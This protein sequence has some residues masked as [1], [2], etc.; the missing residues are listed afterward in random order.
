MFTS[1]Y[2]WSWS[3]MLVCS[4]IYLIMVYHARVRVRVMV[5]VR[6]RDSLI[7]RSAILDHTCSWS[8][9]I[10]VD[11]ARS[12]STMVVSIPCI[13]TCIPDWSAILTQPW[14]IDQQTTVEL[15]WSIGVRLLEWL[16]TLQV[17]V[18]GVGDQSPGNVQSLKCTCIP[19]D[20]NFLGLTRIH[21]E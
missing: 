10:T 12:Y 20:R 13:C 17:C 6:I 9:L 2:C 8:Q 11:H 21:V 5:R 15:W 4:R 18:C 16:S 19:P 3:T 1:N 7:K 14:S